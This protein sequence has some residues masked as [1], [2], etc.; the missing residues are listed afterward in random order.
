M[1]PGNINIRAFIQKLI[2]VHFQ[3]IVICRVIN[4]RRMFLVDYIILFPWIG[5]GTVEN[6][7]LCCRLGIKVMDCAVKIKF[8][9][10]LFPG[11]AHIT[12][13][14]SR[15]SFKQRDHKDQLDIT[16][17]LVTPKDQ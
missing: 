6:V 1:N 14:N 15:G 17:R 5:K 3:H 11:R 13:R 16:E 7:Q 12:E 4:F 10:Q 2:K 8:A 9:C